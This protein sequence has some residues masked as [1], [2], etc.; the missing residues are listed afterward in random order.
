MCNKNAKNSSRYAVGSKHLTIVPLEISRLCRRIVMMSHP[1]NLKSYQPTTVAHWKCLYL[2]THLPARH[3]HPPP[4][5]LPS[6]QKP[7]KN[8]HLMKIETQKEGK[9]SKLNFPSLSSTPIRNAFF[10]P[11]CSKVGSLLWLEGGKERYLKVGDS[12]FNICTYRKR[13]RHE[14]QTN[15]KTAWPT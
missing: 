3:L 9:S 6:K 15:H 1:Q 12:R 8:H 13:E 11:P 4:P 7:Y 10:L 14:T 2:P 5:S